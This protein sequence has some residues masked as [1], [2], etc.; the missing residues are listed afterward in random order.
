MKLNLKTNI[1]LLI[2]VLAIPVAIL[3]KRTPPKPVAPVT[4]DGVTYSTNGD[5]I[6]EF[7][8]ATDAASAKELW[9]A[10]VYSVPVKENL[11]KDVQTIFIRKLKLSG[12]TLFV[13]DEQKRCYQLDVK[14]QKVE[15][16]S[17]SVMKAA[18]STAV[19][20]EKK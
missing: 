11:E 4:G 6:D 18:K 19:S 1:A 20:A 8:V 14:S 2:L 13:S 12:S 10:K 5:G 7:V 15:T 16:I 17:C 9:R 3:A